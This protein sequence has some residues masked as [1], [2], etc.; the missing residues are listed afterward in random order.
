MRLI[1]HHP[2]RSAAATA[3]AKLG[4]A[5][6]FAL[7]ATA[8]ALAQQNAAPVPRQRRQ[9]LVSVAHRK[10]VV[11]ENGHILRVFQVAVGADSSPSP[12]GK[13]QVKTRLVKPTY[14][15]PGKVIAPGAENPL[16]TRWI[17]LDRKGYGIHGTNAP[18]SVGKAASHGCIRMRNADVEEFFELVA[19]GDEVEI[20]G[21]RDAETA[22][23]F[24]PT[25]FED[26]P[27]VVSAAL[28]HSDDA[29]QGPAVRLDG[30]Q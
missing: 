29:T 18:A 15:H 8:S 23:L 21:E 4:A 28:T 13:F 19:A 27:G 24:E 9:V 11:R 30:E 22:A 14:Y 26:Q 20:R 25:T 7:F 16:G 17:G 3:V 6:L 1:N 2:K 5:A 12:T 10:L